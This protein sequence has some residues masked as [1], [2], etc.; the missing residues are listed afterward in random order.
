[1]GSLRDIKYLDQFEHIL[2][3]IDIND[4]WKGFEQFEYRVSWRLYQRGTNDDGT[5]RLARDYLRCLEEDSKILFPQLEEW[6]GP[7][8]PDGRWDFVF[9]WVY[10]F[11]RTKQDF[12]EFRLRIDLPK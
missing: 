1:M 5:P 6:F 12:A 4:G 7:R 3:P 10:L 9:D 11:F 8:G 2:A